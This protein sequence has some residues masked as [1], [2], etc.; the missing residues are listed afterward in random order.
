PKL[1]IPSPT[2]LHFRG[3]RESIDAE[4]YPDME[5]FYADVAR[6][7][8]EEIRD[9]GAAGCHYLQIDDVNFAYICDPR[10]AAQVRGMGEDPDMLPHIYAKLINAAIAAR[11]PG[12]AVGLHVCRR[13]APAGWTGGK[14][15]PGADHPLY[16]VDHS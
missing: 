12:M 5:S 4:A 11:P 1:T 9:L 7:Y 2:I 13:N 15:D 14:H 6:V 3:G 8:N 10:V 16:Q